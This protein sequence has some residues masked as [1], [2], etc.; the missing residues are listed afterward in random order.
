MDTVSAGMIV[1]VSGTRRVMRVP[2][3]GRLSTSTMPPIRSTF[4][5][6]TSIPTPRPEMA[7]TSLAVETPGSKI[8]ASCSA[9]TELGGIRLLDHAIGDGFLDQLFSVDAATVVLDI[10][11]DLVAGLTRGHAEQSNLALAGLPAIGRFFDAMIDGV[12]DNVGQRIADHL[13][14]FAIQLDVAAL[15][16]DQHL[17]VEFRGEVADHARQPHEQILDPLHAGPGD[18]VAHLGNDR[19][20]ALECS[21]DRDVGRRFAK[22]AS[23]FVPRQHHVRHSAHYTVEQFDGQ[24]DGAWCGRGLAVSLRGCSSDRN[25]G[26]LRA[27]CKRSD[28]RAVVSGRKFLAGF[29]SCDHLGDSVDNSQDAADQA[30]VWNAAP[31]SNVSEGILGSVAQGFEPREFEEAAISLHGVNEAKDA[32]EPRAVIGLSLPRHDL[33]AQ[34]F[35]HLAAFGYEIGNQVVHRLGKPPALQCDWLT[36]RGVKAAL[37]LSRRTR[38][39]RR[40]PAAGPWRRSEVPGWRCPKAQLIRRLPTPDCEQARHRPRG[41]Q[42]LPASAARQRFAKDRV[43]QDPRTFGTDNEL[44]LAVAALGSDVEPPAA[45]QRITRQ[46][47]EV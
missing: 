30:R 19:R 31:G 8:K 40:Q 12:P 39:R 7:V 11:E 14:H 42:C 15:N 23:E 43:E 41:L 4:E 26:G 46:K 47:P 3:P 44:D 36:R 10:D 37:S 1:S 21:V 20:Q 18:C 32:I 33:A 24:T 2:S 35:E 6:T 45:H 5:R 17:L 29:D 28:K 27:R 13:D 22:A 25:R 16:I 34:G 38:P 9:W